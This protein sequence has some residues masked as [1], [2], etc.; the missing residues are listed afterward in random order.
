[1][2]FNMQ[3]SPTSSLLCLQIHSRPEHVRNHRP[4]LANNVPR[5]DS[6]S[7]SDKPTTV[8]PNTSSSGTGD[9]GS[10]YHTENDDDEAVDRNGVEVVEDMDVEEGEGG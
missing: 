3:R 8:P 4:E 2:A 10:D 7:S 9:P 6:S 5:L 1:M